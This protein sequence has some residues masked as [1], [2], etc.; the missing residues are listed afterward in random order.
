MIGWE[1]GLT[2]IAVLLATLLYPIVAKIRRRS[3]RPRSG[4]LEVLS[5]GKDA[6]FEFV[7][8]TYSTCASS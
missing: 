4:T 5:D 1:G 3:D 8:T 6:E 7:S 2:V